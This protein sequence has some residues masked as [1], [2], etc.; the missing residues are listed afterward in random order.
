MLTLQSGVGPFGMMDLMV[1]CVSHLT[2]HT[3]VR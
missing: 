2:E 1:N 3:S